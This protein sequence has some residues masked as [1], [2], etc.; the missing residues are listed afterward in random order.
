MPGCPRP[1]LF[2]PLNAEESRMP[3][4][5]SLNGQPESEQ[6]EGPLEIAIVGDLTDNESDLTERLL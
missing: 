5:E 6:E 2:P 1:S 4:N 3:R